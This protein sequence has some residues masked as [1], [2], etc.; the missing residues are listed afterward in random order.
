MLAR[1]DVDQPSACDSGRRARDTEDKPIVLDRSD[2]AL[3][4]EL[5]PALC[6][7]VDLVRLEQDDAAADLGGA[8]MKEKLGAM[9]Q[10]VRCGPKNSHSSVDATR[11]VESFRTRQ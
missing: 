2:R 4:V 5:H 1:G 3:Q 9:A 6:A 10:R 8:C 11:D 7:G